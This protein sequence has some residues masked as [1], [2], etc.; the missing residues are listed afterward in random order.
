[1][2]VRILRSRTDTGRSAGNIEIWV[3]PDTRIEHCDIDINFAVIAV[4]SNLRV[5]RSRDA[6]QARIDDLGLERLLVLLVLV[7]VLVLV[8]MLVLVLS[9]GAGMFVII[10]G[11]AL[12]AGLGLIEVECRDLT[13]RRNNRSRNLLELLPDFRRDGGRES[14]NHV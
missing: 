10:S 9:L 2:S 6:H 5:L 1:M 8:F 13:V 11:F 4:D 3:G 7:L 12:I 14:I